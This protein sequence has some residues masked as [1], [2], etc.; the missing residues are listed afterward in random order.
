MYSISTS[1][2]PVR[3]AVV[4]AAH[5]GW[6]GG[7]SCMEATM[8]GEW[9]AIER[10]LYTKPEVVRIASAIGAT[11]GRS[12]RGQITDTYCTIGALHRVWA[13]ADEQTTDGTLVGYTLKHLDMVI[14]I[15]GFAQAMVDVGWLIVNPQSLTV[16]RFSEHMGQSGK[17]RL[18]DS[19]SKR[20]RRLS[21]SEADTTRTE[22][23]PQEQEEGQE[24]DSNSRQTEQ[25]AA[26]VVVSLLIQEGFK[27]ED[28][29][30]IA[31]L[32]TCT[33]EQ[34]AIA[35]RNA[36][37]KE[38]AGE[39][40]NRLGFIR[41][42]ITRGGALA[43]TEKASDAH[44]ASEAA[45]K[46]R[47]W[48]SQQKREAEQAKHDA[49]DAKADAAKAE[50]ARMSPELQEDGRQRFLATLPPKQRAACEHLPASTFAQAIVKLMSGGGFLEADQ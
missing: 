21:A 10:G 18:R 14:G 5:P 20:V 31:R 30:D 27:Q 39:L 16:P 8:S 13:I 26:V 12:P 15:P 1:R 34:I 25:T 45:R 40:R 36:D 9:I 48:E 38:K 19:K 33:P 41:D 46:R 28:A 29:E 42:V 44:T 6:L 22:S 17:K 50:L 47:Q 35:V 3:L 32:S 2:R 49:E 37:A 11:I 24:E 7:G 43:A 23:G 4:L